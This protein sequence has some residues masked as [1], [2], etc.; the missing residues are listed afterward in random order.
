M[1]TEDTAM[2]SAIYS[3]LGNAYYT[4]GLYPQALEFHRNDLLLTRFHHFFITKGVQIDI[5]GLIIVLVASKMYD[6]YSILQFSVNFVMNHFELE[7]VLKPGSASWSVTRFLFPI[8]TFPWYLLSEGRIYCVMFGTPWR[9]ML[10]SRGGDICVI[11]QNEY[12][13]RW[14]RVRWIGHHERIGW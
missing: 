13:L 9:W 10:L 3:Q 14:R 6:L 8:A 11:E 5:G 2:L 7:N 12:R 4:K 1:G